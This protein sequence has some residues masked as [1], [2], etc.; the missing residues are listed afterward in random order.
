[1]DCVR[2][3]KFR[4][5]PD[6]KRQDAIDNALIL[7]QQLYNKLLEKTIE[8]HK[9]D[10]E[11]KI[12]QRTINLFMNEI[13]NEDKRYYE[14]YSHVRVDIRNRML[15]TYQN[16]FRRVKEK[17]NGKKMKAGFPRFKSRDKYKSI[18]HI[19]NNSSFSI[20]KDRL[21]ISKIG[22]M[23]IIQH[24][25]IE[26]TIKTLTIKKEAGN[27][28]AIFM[29]TKEATPPEIK[30]T[31]PIGIDLGLN[32]FIALSDG[33]TIQKPKFF[34]K[35][36]KRIARWQ[37]IVARRTK[38][39]GRKKAEKQSKR[40]EDAK[41]H[42][43][44]E[45]ANVTNQSNDFAH[46]LADWLINSGYTS[47]AVERLE[48]NNMVKNHNL[49]QSIYNAS[50]RKFIDFLLYKAESAGMRMVKVDPID[51]TQEC[52]SCHNVK[53]GKEKPT[54][55]DRVYNCFVCGLVTDRDINT[56]INI[57]NRAREG[58]SRS[59]AQGDTT[60]AVQHALKSRVD[61]LRTV[62]NIFSGAVHV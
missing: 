10:P 21:R 60:S 55:K 35:K 29:T 50:W 6:K 48:I 36:A 16:F 2:A 32:N 30:D 51:T 15:R 46:K 27:Y 14:L 39:Q 45:W 42:L 58:H 3:Y 9:R 59:H 37:R 33:K 7:S 23:K 52:S 26:G 13:L 28:Y 5:S 34:K 41:A 17:H 40:R 24:R 12:S 22:T 44:Q 57:P 62:K 43:S 56:S 61:E 1:M 4:L 47:F 19:E 53:R 49:A 25:N 31:N 18:M 54:L 8:A 20:E 11:S 38:W